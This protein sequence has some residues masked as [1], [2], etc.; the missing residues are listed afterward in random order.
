[1]RKLKKLSSDPS[2][3]ASAEEFADL[4]EQVC[5]QFDMVDPLN[6]IP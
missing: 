1:M 5:M 6:F 2:L 3:M 4:I